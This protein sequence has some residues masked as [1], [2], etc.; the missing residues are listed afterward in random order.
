[1][2][3]LNRLSAIMERVIDSDNSSIEELFASTDV[4]SIGEIHAF[5]NKII[6]AWTVNEIT[7]GVMYALLKF[8]NM[9]LDSS[10]LQISF[11]NQ[12]PIPICYFS[13][14]LPT[15]ASLLHSYLRTSS[16][17]V[18][19]F[20]LDKTDRHLKEFIEKRKPPVVILTVSQF[21]HVH[22]LRLL[23]QYF[24]DKNLKIVIGGIP[25]VYDESLKQTFSACVF[26]GDLTELTL[27]LENSIKR[28]TDEKM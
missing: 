8:V 15:S 21:L 11:K 5:L 17:T 13:S 22:R 4:Y 9:Y 10:R 2:V 3:S 16:L 7:P 24:N 1:M 28:D 27:L 20:P 19:L 23:V 6:A 26:P 14:Y 18:T 25:F 12:T